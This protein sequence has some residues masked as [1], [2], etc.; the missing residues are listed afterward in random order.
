MNFSDVL[1]KAKAGE[2]DAIY[3]LLERYKTLL[4]RNAVLDGKLDEDLYQE[5]CITFL[6]CIMLF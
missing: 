2:D 3:I 4:L 6:R 1:P 5:L